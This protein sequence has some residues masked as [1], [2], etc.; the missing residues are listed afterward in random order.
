MPTKKPSTAAAP[1]ALTP[2][3]TLAQ[4]AEAV[5]VDVGE[6]AATIA[7]QRDQH[8]PISVILAR[9]AEEVGAVGKGERFNGPGGGYAFRGIDAVVNAVAG[10]LHRAGVVVAPRARKMTRGTATTANNK[11]INTVHVEVDYVFH[12]PAG[13]SLTARVFGEA[14]DS[15]DKATSKA[16]SV[17]FRTALLQVLTL[18]TD[19]PDPDSENYDA[20]HAPAR[21]TEAVQARVDALAADVV[22]VVARTPENTDERRGA[23]QDVWKRAAEGENVLGVEVPIPDGWGEPGERA[24]LGNLIRGAAAVPGGAA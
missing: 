13:D 18:P 19:E 23:L 11:A 7:H 4:A 14:F 22:A 12:G 3:S 24:A 1:G 17:A 21:T 15:G 9:I 6:V 2:D 5:G 8:D 20:Q 10:P 16:M